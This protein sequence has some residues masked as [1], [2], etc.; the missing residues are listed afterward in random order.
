MLTKQIQVVRNC[1]SEGLMTT[2]PL[3]HSAMLPSPREAALLLVSTKNRDLWR[4]LW[5]GPTPEVRDSRTSRRSA[6][7]QSQ[8]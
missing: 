4:R 3:G 5:S 6:N 1:E 7:A 2:R 8:V